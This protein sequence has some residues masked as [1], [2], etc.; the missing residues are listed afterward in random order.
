M[1]QPIFSEEDIKNRHIT[2]AIE[3]AGWAKEQIFMEYCFTDGR[4]TV[5]GKTARRGKKKQADY[6]LTAPNG[7]GAGARNHRPRGKN[8]PGRLFW[9]RPQRPHA[10]G[11]CRSQAR[12]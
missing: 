1:K 11:D 9:A 4:V 7:R 12:R 5:H 2:P 10:A 8:Q 3:A 6:I